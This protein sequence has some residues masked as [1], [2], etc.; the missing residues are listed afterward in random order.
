V[1]TVAV[2]GG[3]SMI[4]SHLVALLQ[5]ER[6]DLRIRVVDNFSA[7][8]RTVL[9]SLVDPERTSVHEVDI[10]DVSAVEDALK[11]CVWVF[12]LAAILSAQFD[13]RLREGLFV[14]T[15]GALNVT[16]VAAEEG[17]RLV[18]SSSAGVYGLPAPG[19]V[20]EETPF[21]H[22]RAAPTVAVYGATKVVG[23]HICRLF[24]AQYP[25][26]TWAALRYTTVYG[27]RQHRRAVHS[28]SIVDNM[29]RLVRGERPVFNG[30]PDEVH[31]YTNVVDLA[32]A[33]LLAAEAPRESANRAYLIATGVSTSNEE[34]A[35]LLCEVA[36]S[37]AE[38]IWDTSED[39]YRIPQKD[40]RF[41]VSAARRYL[42]FVPTVG[43]REGLRDLFE[44]VMNNRETAAR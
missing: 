23:E 13:E 40:V 12:H 24:E 39:H 34:L 35:R 3:A 4:G 25:D 10:T 26:F 16:G 44:S 32:R 20:T 17:A 41:D 19:V 38:P 21:N 30:S 31:D 37:Y 33:N 27:R 8:S 18:F 36:G 22:Q 1:R 11:G 6:P 15:V 5:A 9:E 29:K 7:G 14:N 43:L 42:G 28:I 2:V